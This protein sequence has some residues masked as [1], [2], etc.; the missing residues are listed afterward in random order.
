MQTINRDAKEKTGW[1][2]F[3]RN[4]FSLAGLIIIA[5]VAVLSFTAYLYIPDNSPH[6]NSQHL[7][8]A[9]QKPGFRCEF[10][11][12]QNLPASKKQGF[13]S[14]L[15]KG[16]K[17][18]FQDIPIASYEFT[19][20]SIRVEVWSDPGAEGALVR[21]FH[22]REVVGE[23]GM[24]LPDLRSRIENEHL[25]TKRF[26]LGTD[27]FGRDL[28]SRILLG[29][30]ISISIGLVAVLISLFTGTLL[31]ALAGYYRGRIDD[32][33]MWFINVVW[34]VPTLLLVIA[35]TMVLG[36]GFWQ[37]FIAVGLTMWV[38]VAR[39]VRGQVLSLREK[40]FVDAARVLGMSDMRILF[41]HIFPNLVSPL[42]IIAASN[43]ATA[44]LIEAGLSFLGIGVQPPVPSWGNMIRDHYGFIIVDKAYLA[45]VPGL[46]IMLLVLAFMMVGNGLRDSFDVKSV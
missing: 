41:R 13:F 20:D 7:E 4:P 38:E 22:L 24:N 25:I 12:L 46:A 37:I 3:R 35:L 5:L 15:L 21:S 34:S 1:S 6:A 40:E 9:A 26:L 19:Q 17:S 27:R 10:L 29:G 11:R 16:Q 39:I 2:R 30:R 18:S 42:V 8:I 32:L 44:I 33:I 45:F 36:K 23:E 14:L 31:G 43:F 28:L